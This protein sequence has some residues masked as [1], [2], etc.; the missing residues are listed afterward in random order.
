MGKG[1]VLKK[2]KGNTPTLWERLGG[3]VPYYS[4]LC[5]FSRLCTATVLGS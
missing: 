2:A 5:N 1:V 3:L 4:F